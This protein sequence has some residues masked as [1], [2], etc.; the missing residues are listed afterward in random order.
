[1]TS[2]LY[3]L[4]ATPPHYKRKSPPTIQQPHITSQLKKKHFLK[5]PRQKMQQEGP[6]SGRSSEYVKF[7]ST[8]LPQTHLHWL[9]EVISKEEDIVEVAKYITQWEVKLTVPMEMSSDE[10]YDYKQET[11]PQ[12]QR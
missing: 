9:S 8:Y 12:I 1:M 3:P 11:R 10:I 2:F 4:F 6:L 5:A 7:V